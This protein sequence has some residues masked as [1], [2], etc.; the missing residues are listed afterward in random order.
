MT[1]K[2]TCLMTVSPFRI[3]AFICSAS[4]ECCLNSQEGRVKPKNKTFSFLVGI[5]HIVMTTDGLC[6]FESQPHRCVNMSRIGES[7]VPQI[8]PSTKD[9]QGQLLASNRVNG[10][11]KG[12]DG[13]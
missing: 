6:S 2:A 5:V 8:S 11:L 10:S 3:F 4:V 1:D 9:K 7:S 12:T 13:P